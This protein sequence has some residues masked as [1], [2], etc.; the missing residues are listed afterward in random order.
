MTRTQTHYEQAFTAQ[1]DNHNR[2]QQTLRLFEFWVVER[3]SNWIFLGEG[4]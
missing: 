1:G 4:D 3:E 2:G